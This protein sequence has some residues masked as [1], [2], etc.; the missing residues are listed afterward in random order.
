MMNLRQK[1]GE[2]VDVEWAAVIILCFG[3]RV[4]KK[5]SW[6]E[7]G[8]TV[9]EAVECDRC[10]CPSSS[11]VQSVD[12]EFIAFISNAGA[13]SGGSVL[14]DRLE[15]LSDDHGAMHMV[16]IARILGEVHLFV[17]HRMCDEPQ[18]IEMLEYN[19]GTTDGGQVDE[20][21]ELGGEKVD[22]VDKMGDAGHVEAEPEGVH[23][24]LVEDELVGGEPE[25]GEGVEGDPV[26][27]E[28]IQ[29]KPLEAEPLEPQGLEPEPL[30]AE[31]E[32]P[33]G[34]EPEPLQAEPHRE[35]TV[36][37]SDRVAHVDSWS[38]SGHHGSTQESV[39]GANV[40]CMSNDHLDQ[41]I[42]SPL[43][44]KICD[45]SWC[46]HN[47]LTDTISVESTY[48]AN[49]AKLILQSRHDYPKINQAVEC[50]RCPCPSSSRVQS[51]DIEFIAFISNAGAISG[52]S[53][54]EDRLELLSDD[55][56]A[57][58]MVTIAR[59][60]GE[61]HL[62]VVH[63]MCDEPQIIE[64]LEYNVGTTDGGQVDEVGELG[65][66]KVDV[67]DKMGDAGHVEAEPEGVHT[68]LVEDELVGGEPERG[69]GVEGDPVEGETIQ[70]K[71][72]EAEPLEPQGLEPEPLEA[73]VEEPQGL[74]PEPLQAEPHREHTVGTSDRVAHVDSWSDSGH[75]GSTQE[76]VHGIHDE[77]LVGSIG[78]ELDGLSTNN[79]GSDSTSEESHSPPVGSIG[80]ELD[81]LST[82]NMGS[83][84]TSEESH[85]PP[86]GSIGEELDGL[87]TNNMG[88]DSTSEESHSPPVGSIGEEL[89]GL[90]TNNMGS[91]STSEESHSPPVGSIGEEL[92]GLSTNN[93]GSDSTS[94]E[95]H[96]PPHQGVQLNILTK[97]H[98]G[99][100]DQ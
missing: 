94:E 100:E 65:G 30:E 92:D 34:L 69:E 2:N 23:T 27:G 31:V 84:S 74:E 19:V 96:S 58:H 1:R 59:I 45:V 38:D 78:E 86:V 21:G 3:F 20:V 50:D 95:S 73:E 63:R 71:P 72:L 39:H 9:V 49:I 32:E 7:I 77:G 6:G 54:L 29:P 62:F 4:F 11:R 81:G 42:L 80:E 48:M 17:V 98:V 36:G 12:I 25:R 57:M 87:S 14:E 88:S 70:P 82:N 46:H 51:V 18:I 67:V 8:E 89:D 22:V 90:S 24:V 37:T 16:T 5:E 83:D 15:L 47:N 68:V 85:S 40:L 44:I 26:E 52:G 56:G 66:E 10:P 93:M 41:D 97:D 43:V 53:V 60:L 55:H 35:H 99:V 91:D 64:M 33:Q 75:H 61:V 76:S 13:I 79:M 28:T